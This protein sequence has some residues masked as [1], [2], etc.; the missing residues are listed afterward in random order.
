MDSKLNAIVV[1]AT[2]E[3]GKAIVK[4]LVKRPQFEKV[5]LIV[6]RYLDIP[7]S[8]DKYRKIEQYEKNRVRRF[9]KKVF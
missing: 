4:E 5:T 7:E 6:R 1:G 2:G 9:N 3:V 8:D